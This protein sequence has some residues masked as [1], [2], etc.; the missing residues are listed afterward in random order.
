MSRH[1]ASPNLIDRAKEHGK[2]FIAAGTLIT[3][4]ALGLA[5]C[6]SNAEAKPSPSVTTSSE[7]PS[8]TSS[9]SSTASETSTPKP[10]ETQKPTSNLVVDYKGF[11]NW[12]SREVP[13][14]PMYEHDREGSQVWLCDKFYEANGLTSPEFNYN[15][16][17]WKGQ[18]ITA[19]IQPRLELAWKLNMD[20]SNPDNAEVADHLL[21]CLTAGPGSDAYKKLSLQFTDARS[22]SFELPSPA[23]DMDKITRENQA[24]WAD[25]I[26]ITEYATK[27]GHGDT[28]YPKITYQNTIYTDWRIYSIQDG[29]NSENPIDWGPSAP[30]VIDQ[31]RATA[32]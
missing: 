32:P 10:V 22:S 6:A 11:A 23:K 20:K 4:G 15:L 13:A 19:Y 17:K 3:I 5:G 27:D 30:V 7:A 21:S 18:E 8:P 31:S 12:D 26:Y 28:I 2:K 29:S 14:N 25:S 16:Q 24:M 1:E 9:P